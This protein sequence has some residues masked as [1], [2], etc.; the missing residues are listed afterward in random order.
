MTVDGQGSGEDRAEAGCTGEVAKERVD[1]RLV[2]ADLV[3]GALEAGLAV[4]DGRGADGPVD[5]SAVGQLVGVQG[6]VRDLAAGQGLR[7]DAGNGERACCD[8]GG[9]DRVDVGGL[10]LQRAVL[11]AAAADRA[12]GGDDM[13]PDGQTGGV[14]QHDL[15][16]V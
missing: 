5:D 15:G 13:P 10:D 4:G 14:H 9:V 16:S 1:V 6:L 3:Q 11:D 2:G 8:L 12:G 7:G